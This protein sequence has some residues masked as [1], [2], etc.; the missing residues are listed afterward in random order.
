MTFCGWAGA[1]YV[2]GGQCENL[3]FT[4]CSRKITEYRIQARFLSSLR[5]MN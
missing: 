4:F 5:R 2:G 3:T 1:K